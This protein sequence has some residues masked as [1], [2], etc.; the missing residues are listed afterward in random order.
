MVMGVM[1]EFSICNLPEYD[2]QVDKPDSLLSTLSIIG[3]RSSM[4]GLVVPMGNPRYVNGK[5]PTEQPKVL[6]RHSILSGD[7]NWQ[8]L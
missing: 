5:E 2:S 8:H 7:I 6:D 4:R 3:V 1:A